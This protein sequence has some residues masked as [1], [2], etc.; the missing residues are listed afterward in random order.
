MSDLYKRALAF[1]TEKHKG[2]TD[3][4]GADYID[5]PIRVAS[6]VSDPVLKP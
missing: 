4:S 2:Q 6:R 3:K 1:A 5:H